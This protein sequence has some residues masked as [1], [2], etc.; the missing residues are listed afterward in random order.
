MKSSAVI[1]LL[2]THHLIQAQTTFFLRYQ[3]SEI[4]EL[5]PDGC[6]NVGEKC[7]FSDDKF[8]RNGV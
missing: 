1:K 5:R 3:V 4:E 8:P 7:T 2:L 6:F